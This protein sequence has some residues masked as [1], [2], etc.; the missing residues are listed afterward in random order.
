MSLVIIGF[1]ALMAWGLSNKVPVT[2]LSG[3]TRVQ[4]PPPPF[5]LTL[6]DGGEVDLALEQGKPI[7]INFWASWCIPCREEASVLEQT[8]RSF[9]DKD[10]LF[11]GVNIQDVDE[12]A[13]AHINE[14]GITYPNGLDEGGKITVD[15]G[16]IGIFY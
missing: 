7:V 12:A 4:K 3:I 10:V 6:F 13:R 9:R 2:G 11:I 15:Y 16:V 8:W 5:N 14:F 1:F